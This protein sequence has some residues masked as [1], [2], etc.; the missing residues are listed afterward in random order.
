MGSMTTYVAEE[1]IPVPYEQ[2]RYEHAKRWLR[3]MLGDQLA[4][5]LAP[6]KPI[7]LEVTEAERTEMVPL[8]VGKA[9]PA[10]LAD[11]CLVMQLVVKTTPVIDVDRQA[12]YRDKPK[13]M[14]WSSAHFNQV[15]RGLDVPAD[16]VAAQLPPKT[17]W[18]RFSSWWKEMQK[19]MPYDG[20]RG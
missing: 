3:R 8:M 20:P 16:V 13:Y 12:I 2:G 18:Q 10:W 5:L 17:Q 4:K 11:R 14:E 9:H 15:C 6:G 19:P 1:R 7:A